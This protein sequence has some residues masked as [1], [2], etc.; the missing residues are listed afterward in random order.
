MA[1]SGPSPA[2][3]S[4]ASAGRTSSPAISAVPRLAYEDQDLFAVAEGHIQFRGRRID[5][6]PS[7]PNRPR[8]TAVAKTGAA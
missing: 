6:V 8:Y 7:D 4:S 2:R 5:I 3:S 1:V